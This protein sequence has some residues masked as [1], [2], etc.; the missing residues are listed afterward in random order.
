VDHHAVAV[1]LVLHHQRPAGQHP[2]HIGGPRH[3][4]QHGPQRVEQ[5]HRLRST[6]SRRRSRAARAGHLALEAHRRVGE[7]RADLVQ[8]GADVEQVQRVR[9][10]VLQNRLGA[11]A[12]LQ[13]C[14]PSAQAK[15]L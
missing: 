5:P 1:V 4:R 11:Q 8:V 2:D 15:L 13:V 12:D 3:L 7:P 6:E 10:E 9:V 14:A